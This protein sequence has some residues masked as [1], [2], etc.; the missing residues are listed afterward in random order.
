VIAK[1]LPWRTRKKP[2]REAVDMAEKAKGWR[3]VYR[4]LAK[5]LEKA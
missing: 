4:E 5:R 1:Q 3:K 2:A